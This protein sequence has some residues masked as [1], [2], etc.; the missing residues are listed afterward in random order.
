M[1]IGQVVF[2]FGF[3]AVCGFIIVSPADAGTRGTGLLGPGVAV[4][5]SQ[6]TETM[7]GYKL[8]RKR[9]PLLRMVPGGRI[10]PNCPPSP[11]RWTKPCGRRF[12][13]IPKRR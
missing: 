6:R 11:R 12:I 4:T 8:K 13:V 7:R 5:P 2:L 3:V 9:M 10:K 1:K